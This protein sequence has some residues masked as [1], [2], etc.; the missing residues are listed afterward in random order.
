MRLHGKEVVTLLIDYDG[1]LMDSAER[2]LKCV[3]GVLKHY[4]VKPLSLAQYHEEFKQPFMEFYRQYIPSLTEDEEVK[5]YKNVAMEIPPD[6]RPDA[7][8]VLRQLKEKGIRIAIV[9][10][11]GQEEIEYFLGQ[12]GLKDIFFDIKGSILDKR[13]GIKE[14]MDKQPHNFDYVK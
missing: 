14:F 7:E 10:C 8:K 3:N 9:S 13:I 12:Y 4:G 1:T 11:N 5:V 2:G 6:L